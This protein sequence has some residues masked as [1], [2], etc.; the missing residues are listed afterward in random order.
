MLLK[1]NLKMSYFKLDQSKFQLN[2]LMR[3]KYK[4]CKIKLSNKGIS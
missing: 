3:I 4:N 1:K 2:S